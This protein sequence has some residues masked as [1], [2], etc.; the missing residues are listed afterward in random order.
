MGLFAPCVWPDGTRGVQEI[1]E[2][3]LA[4]SLPHDFGDVRVN[5]SFHHSSIQP[6]V[7]PAMFALYRGWAEADY[8]QIPSLQKFFRAHP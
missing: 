3:E 6:G 8:T 5:V 2:H 1:Q 7:A 4:G